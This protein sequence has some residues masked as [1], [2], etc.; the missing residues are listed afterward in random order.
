LQGSIQLSLCFIYFAL[1]PCITSVLVGRQFTL[2]IRSS[3]SF[4]PLRPVYW[5][6]LVLF[7]SH[8]FMAGEVS[9]LFNVG[10]AISHECAW[11]KLLLAHNFII[12]LNFEVRSIIKQ[13]YLP[14]W[15]RVWTLEVTGMKQQQES[16][17]L[18]EFRGDLL[19]LSKWHDAGRCHKISS[20]QAQLHC[21][22]VPV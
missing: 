15:V 9:T 2:N 18:G 22:I 14:S 11:L 21:Y 1:S 10:V 5:P 8:K 4:C 12:H 6:L 16:I 13:K 17:T 19:E 7:G 20:A 3:P